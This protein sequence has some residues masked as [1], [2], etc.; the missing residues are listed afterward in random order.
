HQYQIVI[1]SNQISNGVYKPF[2]LAGIL[3]TVVVFFDQQDSA[4]VGPRLRDFGP[5]EI[6]AGGLAHSDT[7]SNA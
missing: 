2:L 4:G 3:G 1:A 5:E 7:N 6:E